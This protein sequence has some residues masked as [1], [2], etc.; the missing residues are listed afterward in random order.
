M[1]SSLKLSKDDIYFLSAGLIDVVFFLSALLFKNV[2][3][4]SVASLL[5]LFLTF[6]LIFYGKDTDKLS[7]KNLG[8]FMAVLFVAGVF[9]AWWK[10]LLSMGGAGADFF[11][12]FKFFLETLV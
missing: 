5:Y 8:Y 4:L 2:H 6:S 1:L 12:L 7:Y 11:T 9:L 3:V 10:L